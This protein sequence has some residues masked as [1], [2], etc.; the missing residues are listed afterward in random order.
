MDSV[1]SVESV[2][3]SSPT[4]YP[5][6]GTNH[7]CTL[8]RLKFWCVGV[9]PKLAS[10]AIKYG[11]VARPSVVEVV[12]FRGG[13]RTL[14]EECSTTVAGLRITA[15]LHVKRL[16]RTASS[17]LYSPC[18]VVHLAAL[19]VP[20]DRAFGRTSD[21]ASIPGP[22]VHDAGLVLRRTRWCLL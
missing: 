5:Q 13:M 11:A 2:G 12:Q 3:H 21:A 7:Q 19:A 10:T 20:H 8:K 6:D 15:V 1:D 9:V 18:D 16:Y 14:V 22:H 17:V 4:L